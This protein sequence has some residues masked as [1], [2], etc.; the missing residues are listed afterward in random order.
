MLRT[1]QLEPTYYKKLTWRF[2]IQTKFLVEKLFRD[3]KINN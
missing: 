1:Y 2:L 3:E